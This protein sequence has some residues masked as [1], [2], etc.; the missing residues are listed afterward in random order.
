MNKSSSKITKAS[1]LRDVAFIL[2]NLLNAGSLSASEV[3]KNTGDLLPKYRTRLHQG[4]IAINTKGVQFSE[5]VSSLFD[6]STLSVVRAGE[7]SGTLGKVFEQI[8]IAAKTQCE[9]QKI[10]NKLVLPVVLTFFGVIVS[11][12]F[13]IGLIPMIYESLSNGAPASYEPSI[14]IQMAIATNAFFISNIES[15]SIVSLIILIGSAFMITRPSVQSYMVDLVISSIIKVRFIGSSYANLKFGVL[16]QYIQTVSA[17]GLDANRRIDLVIDI[18]PP[19][20]R[21]G[22]LAF[23]KDFP[24]KGIAYAA[25]SEGKPE[26]DPRHSDVLWPPYLRLAFAQADDGDWET[27]MPVSYTHLTLPTIYSV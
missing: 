10:L 7:E 13:F 9:I 17:A 6:E 18:L 20:L 27:P 3:L 24:I 5:A 16:A 26:S 8:W 12:V 15:V 11:L 14:M 2:R 25:R 21:A 4:A 22:M 1:E 19:P 23:R